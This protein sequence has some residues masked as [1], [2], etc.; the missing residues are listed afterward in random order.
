M[1]IFKVDAVEVYF[2]ETE[3]DAGIIVNMFI[4]GGSYE[5]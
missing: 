4:A 2:A 3:V 5:R 1:I